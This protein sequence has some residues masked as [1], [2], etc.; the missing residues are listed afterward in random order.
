MCNLNWKNTFKKNFKQINPFK[1]IRCFFSIYNIS[2]KSLCSFAFCIKVKHV[3]VFVC[4][5]LC[6]ESSLIHIYQIR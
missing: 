2:D 1:A 6:N 3:L 4:R 5:Y